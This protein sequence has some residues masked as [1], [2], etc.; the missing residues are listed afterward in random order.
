MDSPPKEFVLPSGSHC[1]MLSWFALV[2]W[3][4]EN[5][6]WGLNV[7]SVPAEEN[8]ARTLNRGYTGFGT[9]SETVAGTQMC[10]VCGVESRGGVDPRAPPRCR[11]LFRLAQAVVAFRGRRNASSAARKKSS[12]SSEVPCRQA[13]DVKVE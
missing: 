6:F 4:I 8:C 7:L 9:G 5:G 3:R 13:K 2:C 12:M 11:S 1:Q 10:R